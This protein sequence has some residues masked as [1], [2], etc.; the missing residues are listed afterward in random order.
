MGPTPL[1]RNAGYHV[2]RQ[3]TSVSSTA[4]PRQHPIIPSHAANARPATRFSRAIVESFARPRL[5]HSERRGSS[6]PAEVGPAVSIPGIEDAFAALPALSE[7]VPSSDSLVTPPSG[8]VPPIGFVSH[9]GSAWPAAVGS[10]S[11]PADWLSCAVGTLFCAASPLRLLG[12]FYVAFVTARR[13]TLF[14]PW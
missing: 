6:A 9:D 8:R 14:F 13:F 7:T 3:P 1:S 5:C 10:Q 4:S 2:C 11:G 12:F